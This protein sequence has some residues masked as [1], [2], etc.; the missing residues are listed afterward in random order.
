MDQRMGEASAEPLLQRKSLTEQVYE[1]LERRIV[2]G[3]L[4]PGTRL[5]PPWAWIPRFATPSTA[6][7]A[8]R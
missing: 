3:E 4:T 7:R 1:I 2:D 6:G 5:A 8:H